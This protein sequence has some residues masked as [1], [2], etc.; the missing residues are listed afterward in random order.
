MRIVM[1]GASG[2]LGTTL[3]ERF[4]ADGHDVI[5]LVRR[6]AAGADESQ[7][8]PDANAVDQAVVESADVVVNTAGV[9]LVGNVHSAKWKKAVIGSRVRTTTVLA[10]AIARS[11]GRAA[12][13]VSNGIAYYGDHGDEIVTEESPSLGNAFLRGVTQAWQEATTPA[14]H[15]GSR[16]CVLRTSPVATKD[17]PL[18]KLQMPL[19]KLGLGARMGSGRQYAPLIS[20]RDWIGAVAY[21]AS[22]PTAS[23]PVNLCCP[24]TPTNKEFTDALASAL[25]RKAFLAAPAPI[26]RVAAGPMAPEVL[27]SINLRP[28]ALEEAGYEF[29]DR[30]VR[31][32]LTAML[33]A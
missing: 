16:V 6:P 19:F 29:Q 9:S 22:H 3:A 14:V 15:A 10:E 17:N 1:A 25:N 12:F 31:A 33:S 23:G 11:G 2:L 7:W 26:L 13:L 18:F 30:D 21:L 5:R 20:L 4:R 28:A 8:D 24:V 27:S 32:V